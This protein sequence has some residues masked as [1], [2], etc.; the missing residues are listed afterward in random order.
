MHLHV[1]CST[2]YSSQATEATYVCIDGWVD[3]EN[4]VC[5]YACTHAHTHTREYYPGVKKN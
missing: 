1:H 4:A 2:I 3:K 5:V